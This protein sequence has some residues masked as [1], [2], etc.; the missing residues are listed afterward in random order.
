[1]NKKMNYFAVIPIW[2][3]VVVLLWLYIKMVKRK[4]N[5]KK[6]HACFASSALFGFLSILVTVLFLNF[7][8]AR[9]DISDFVNNYGLLTAFICGGYLM[10]LFTF[11]LV[12][13]K[14]D[15]LEN[16]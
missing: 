8:N 13:K 16:P 14:W 3:T 1:M 6:F 5:K 2:G 12:N 7:I 4:I 9:I 15:A 10:N 11:T